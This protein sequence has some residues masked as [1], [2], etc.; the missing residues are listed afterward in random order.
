MAFQS[1]K[2]PLVSFTCGGDP[3]KDL[4]EVDDDAKLEEESVVRAPV[5]LCVMVAEVADIAVVAWVAR[6]DLYP[7]YRGRCYVTMKR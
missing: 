7:I 6:C 5:V 2:L 3:R 1:R 4:V